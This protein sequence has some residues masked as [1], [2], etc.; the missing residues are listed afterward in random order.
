MLEYKGETFE[1]LKE[2]S[3]TY[4]IE[5][6]AFVYRYKKWGLERAIETEY[7]K[8]SRV[9]PPDIIELAEENGVSYDLLYQ[10]YYGGMDMF[11]AAIEP[12]GIKPGRKTTEFTDEEIEKLA[13]IGLTPRLVR[14]RRRAGWTH[15]EAM[16]IPKGEKRR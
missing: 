6:Q 13:E 4:R 12:V 14:Q 16:N 8:S 1:T 7:T 2:V 5:Y 9:F 11:D 3:D 15:Y 10:R